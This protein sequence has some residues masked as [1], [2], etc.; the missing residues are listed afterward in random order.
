MTYEVSFLRR[1][2]DND[3]LS[4]KATRG[5]GDDATVNL[6]VTVQAPDGSYVVIKN[7]AV[8]D[9]VVTTPQTISWPIPK[10]STGAFMRGTY[11]FSLYVKQTVTSPSV[12]SLNKEFA[13]YYKQLGD[14][15]E[16]VWEETCIPG[17]AAILRF[18]D[19][20]DYSQLTLVSRSMTVIF[21]PEEG[22]PASVSEL[23]QVS[24][25][26]RWTNTSY[27]GI[28]TS[29]YGT[30]FN[31]VS[32]V[33][34][35]EKYSIVGEAAHAFKCGSCEVFKCVKE[36]ADKV[37]CNP[38]IAT[39]ATIQSLLLNVEAYRAAAS[40]GDTASMEAY[41]KKIESITGCGCG[42]SES[43]LPQ[44]FDNSLL[45]DLVNSYSPIPTPWTLIAQS[46]TYL[47]GWDT[48]T[49]A[50]PQL[51][52]RKVGPWVELMGTVS[53]SGLSAG[54][55][56]VVLQGYFAARGILL[57]QFYGPGTVLAENGGAPSMTFG[58][59][60]TVQSGNI[61][62]HVSPSV[63]PSGTSRFYIHVLIP[64]A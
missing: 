43:T 24:V 16:V 37:S 20:T 41:A 50:S 64:T 60:I 5:G 15:A 63:T 34:V 23:Y 7:D 51:Q 2:G 45:E 33:D 36:F 46:E 48:V 8:P 52:W 61:A 31:P 28:L 56:Y 42:C 25:M 12:I 39:I 57:K 38:G 9:A 40:C 17:T 59:S 14:I 49:N 10:D 62:V 44:P 58:G 47:S 27:F 53:K 19:K 1:I 30:D 29:E 55:A 4:L 21:P 6:Y 18:V 13:Y 54:Q 22:L 11:K 3:M 26:P 35:F 32:G